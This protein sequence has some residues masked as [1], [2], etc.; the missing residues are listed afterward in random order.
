MESKVETRAARN[1][2]NNCQKALSYP[3]TYNFDCKS[4]M[5]RLNHPEVAAIS[6]A[7]PFWARPSVWPKIQRKRFNTTKGS[8]QGAAPFWVP[9]HAMEP[10]FLAHFIALSRNGLAAACSD[11]DRVKDCERTTMWC[12]CKISFTWYIYKELHGH[13]LFILELKLCCLLLTK[14]PFTMR[15]PTNSSRIVFKVAKDWYATF[16]WCRQQK[17]SCVGQAI[18]SNKHLHVT[19][20]Q[21]VINKKH[22]ESASKDSYWWF[23]NPLILIGMFTHLNKPCKVR[24]A[25]IPPIRCLSQIASG[26]ASYAQGLQ[27]PLQPGSLMTARLY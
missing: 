22:Q 17:T 11:S 3:R 23:V 14:G 21:F 13:S 20:T 6:K 10:N 1:Q 12:N 18:K 27:M 8:T 19:I 5:I 4:L 9:P 24:F 2:R 7:I 25:P 16:T 26:T 15:P